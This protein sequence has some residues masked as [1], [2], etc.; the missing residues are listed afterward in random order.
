MDNNKHSNKYKKVSILS[1]IA[2]ALLCITSQSTFASTFTYNLLKSM[3]DKGDTQAQTA[4]GAMYATG[5]EVDKNT[6]EAIKWFLKAAQAGDP[7]AKQ[8]LG[9]TYYSNKDYTN[10]LKWL[11]ITAKEGDIK[12]QEML[13]M[14][15]NGNMGIPRDP[16]LAYDWFSVAKKQDSKLA[17]FYLKQLEKE[18][19]GKPLDVQ[20]KEKIAKSKK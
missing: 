15:Y 1:I 12:S 9:L 11:N 6:N 7:K 17:D 20:I 16:K 8:L 18:L 19:Y 10:A 14:L 3:A 5:R 4:I 2:A 13:G